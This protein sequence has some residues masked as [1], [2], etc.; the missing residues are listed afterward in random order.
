MLL[1]ILSLTGPF[2]AVIVPLLIIKLI[3]SN[4]WQINKQSYFIVFW[5]SA[6]Q[7]FVILLSERVTIGQADTSLSSW[8]LSFIQIILFST[9]TPSL[10]LTAISF[11]CI[12]LYTLYHFV[13]YEGQV[14]GKKIAPILFLCAAFILIISAIY[15]HKQNPLSAV[16]LG[17]GN[18]YTWI[19]YTLIIYSALLISEKI[20]PAK[21]ILVGLMSTICLNTLHVVSSKNLQFDSFAKFSEKKRVLIPVLPQWPVFPSWHI[22]GAPSKAITPT[23][24]MTI[25]LQKDEF[26]PNDLNI[27]SD[28]D[29][30][31]IAT[32]SRSSFLVIKNKIECKIADNFAIEIDMNRGRKGWVQLFWSNSYS[33]GESDSLRIWYP[34]GAIVSQFAFFIP[35]GMPYIRIDPAEF[36]DTIEINEIRV[37]CLE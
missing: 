35:G 18:R 27:V 22:L 11:W 13:K 19:P 15:S 16:T 30:L 12:L 24:Y 28:A 21:V 17:A 1:F 14:N 31:E 25:K 37:F 2:S 23:K 36:P 6:I 20:R 33:F 9:D 5:C 3:V 32:K 4:D 26:I 29:G 10:S 7:V 34:S 8:I